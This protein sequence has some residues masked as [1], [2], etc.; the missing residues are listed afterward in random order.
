V[1]DVFDSL[2]FKPIQKKDP[3]A[4]LGFKPSAAAPVDPV[5]AAKTQNTATG[6]NILRNGT[7]AM[8]EVTQSPL[9]YAKA[10]GGEAV[11]YGKG[12]AKTA[13]NTA[14]VVGAGMSGQ[15]GQVVS[16]AVN[17]PDTSALDPKTLAE[18]TGNLVEGG[19]EL[20]AG[21]AKSAQMI[22]SAARAGAKFAAVEG[23]AGKVP[24]DINAPGQAALKIQELADAGGSM[25][26]V[27]RKFLRRV[28]DPT[29][30]PMTYDEARKFYSNATRLSADEFNKLTPVIKRGVGE[31]TRGLNESI[32]NAAGQVGQGENYQAAM[33]EFRNAMKLKGY[34]EKAIDLL[35]KT[36]AGMGA[37]GAGVYGVKK[38]ME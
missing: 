7:V 11:G 30:P 2:G 29:Q 16:A 20:A 8:P 17:P 12:A 37:A 23:A 34:T 15:P 36:L 26:M 32:T 10:L 21:L 28:T 38:V 22:P 18:K 19:T 4:D 27:V 24:I 35:W 5:A 31:F 25:P 33:S 13:I 1:S 6:Q 3:F 14:N 9:D